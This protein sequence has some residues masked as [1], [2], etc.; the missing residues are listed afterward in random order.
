MLRVDFYFLLLIG[1]ATYSLWRGRRD[2][3][4]A[5]LTCVVASVASMALLITRTGYYSN[6]EFGVALID[7]LALLTFVWIALKSN[8]FWPLWVAG[9]QMTATS[10]HVFKLVVPNLLPVV[11]ATSLASWS[12][13]I[14]L[15]I[16][17]GIWRGHRDSGDGRSITLN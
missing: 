1:V 13:P 8:R 7:L 2:E 11:Y 15:I 16:A 14:L 17:L 10:G 12:Y 4:L 3:Q 5:A 9:L 6:F